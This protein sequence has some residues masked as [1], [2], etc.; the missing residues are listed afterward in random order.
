MMA[1]RDLIKNGQI[2]MDMYLEELRNRFKNKSLRAKRLEMHKSS[3]RSLEEAVS[4]L[5][6]KK[7]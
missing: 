6:G 3:G 5:K 1:Q 4:S 7:K 2:T